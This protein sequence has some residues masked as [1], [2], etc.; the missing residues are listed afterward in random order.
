MT[1]RTWLLAI[2]TAT[3]RVLVAAGAPDGSLIASSSFVAE[4]RHG[5]RLIGAVNALLADQQLVLSDLRGVIV[6]TG[7]GAFTGLRVGLATAKTL[8][9]ELGVPIAG[10]PTGEA[11]LVAA[12]ELHIA[13]PSDGSPSAEPAGRPAEAVL[14]L[15]AGPHDRVEVRRGAQPRML[16]GDAAPHAAADGPDVVIAVDL[17]GRAPEAELERGRRAVEGLAAALLRL[18][19][20]RLAASPDDAERLVPEYVTL[21]RGVRGSLDLE[22]GV[23]WS[24]D[25]R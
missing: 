17:P 14:L 2:D 5:E 21:P 25:R 16:A 8:A 9:H 23:A 13:D 24:H 18:G 11:L 1:D 15:P 19:A 6:G 20:Q 10:I 22:G 12:G 3:S 7:P 4:H